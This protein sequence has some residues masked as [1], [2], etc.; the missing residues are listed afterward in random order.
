MLD[1]A[2]RSSSPTR[3]RRWLDPRSAGTALGSCR[4]SYPLVAIEALQRTRDLFHLEAFDDVAGLDVLVVFERHAAFVT[5]IDLPNFVLEALQRFQRAFVDH[6]IVT[7]QANP[8]TA[9]HGT[10]GHH[11][12][13]NLADLRDGEDVADR[14]VAKQPLAYRRRKQ[15]RQRTPHVFDQIIYNRVITDF[16]AIAPGKIAGL[17]VGAHIKAN[18][19]G[20][21]R[22]GQN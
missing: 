19:H 17:R 5:L 10:L 12:P 20:F 14:S 21:R 7:Q 22:L 8:G 2:W 15:T 1:T 4:R 9:P 6:D 16:D 18:N 13:G 3:S 11:A